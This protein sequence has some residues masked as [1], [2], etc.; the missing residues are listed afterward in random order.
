VLPQVSLYPD[1][2]QFVSLRYGLDEG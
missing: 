1:D 2:A